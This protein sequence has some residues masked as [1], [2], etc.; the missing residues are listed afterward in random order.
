MENF[1]LGPNSNNSTAIPIAT[2]KGF[3][4]AFQKFAIWDSVYETVVSLI[5]QLLMLHGKNDQEIV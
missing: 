2:T 1:W 4:A 5:S 3:K